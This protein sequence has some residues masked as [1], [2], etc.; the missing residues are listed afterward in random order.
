[1]RIIGGT[2]R[3]RRIETAGPL[4]RPLLERVREAVFNILV[5]EVDGATVWDLFAG[6][7]ANGIEALSRGAERVLFVE[8]ANRALRVLHGN[9]DDLDLGDDPQV[10]VLR[11]NAWDPPLE[12]LEDASKAREAVPDLVFL[13]PPYPDVRS[14][15]TLAVDRVSNLLQRVRPG[16]TL[17]F[18]FPDGVLDEDDL[19]PL[20][21]VDLR[22]W[23]TTAVAFLE[24]A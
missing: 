18:H 17:V 22:V 24:R 20:G 1:M 16:G 19:S 15:P 11:G 3:G 23:G 12:S 14:D 4:T 2:F 8:K 21:T 9:L 10:E 7:G 5:D 13:D 6:T